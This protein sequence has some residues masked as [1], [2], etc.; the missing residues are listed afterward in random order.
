MCG[1]VGFTGKLSAKEVLLNGLERLEYRGYDSAG[2]SV[3]TPEQK[4][5]TC[6]TMG[7]ISNLKEAVKTVDDN[8]KCGIGHTRW[9]T[10]GVPS[11]VNAHPHATEKLSLVHNGIIENYLEI[12]NFLTEKGYTFISQ[13]DTEIA[14]KL[15][16]YYYNGDAFEAIKKAC[17]MFEG[18][19][20]FAIVF[21]DKPGEIFATRKNSPLIVSCSDDGLFLASDISAVLKYTNKFYTLEEGEVAH[22]A[23]GEEKFYDMDKNPISKTISVSS[24]TVENAEKCGYDHFMLKE[25]FDQPVAL[26]RT[27]TPR[28]SDE[29]LPVF[30]ADN[31]SEDFFTGYNNIY[32]VACGTAY[33]AGMLGGQVLR[34]I[35]NINVFPV[36]ASEFRYNPPVL[37][38]KDLV[39]VLS[40]S[41]E[42]ADTLAALKLAKEKNVPNLAIVNV[43]GSAIALEADNVMYTYAG[44]EIAVASTKA[45]SVQVSLFYLMGV[46]LAMANG[47]MSKDEAKTFIDTFLETI[48]TFGE[49]FELQE[50]CKEIAK[51]FL[52]AHSMFYI[53]RGLDSYLA[54]EAALKLKEVSYVHCEA[55]AA[56]ELKHGTLSLI[57][58]ETPVIAL[59]T[60]EKL[61]QKT[62]SNIREVTARGGKVTVITLDG[63]QIPKDAYDEKLVLNCKA[64]IF[65]PLKAIVPLQ[66]LAYYTSCLKGLDVDKPRN[67]AKSVTVE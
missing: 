30:A 43:Q 26:E 33:Y 17:E 37:S 59:V 29:N 38:E 66:F 23:N 67:L 27:V 28:I 48:K 19:Y 50:Q 46:K 9:A 18:A 54:L 31:I 12:S 52:N 57:T 41:G 60:D 13:T 22:L 32:V 16:D 40:Q 8:A 45:F 63:V 3:F 62:I 64:D 36:I 44:T 20:A 42:T 34:N 56:G 47:V 53:G 21:Y 6:K 4:I 10:H 1:I 15:V 25:I 58:E 65:A 14:S 61:A 35:A 24:L 49:T 55:Y 11:D 5:V 2:I 51:G 39:I 7:R